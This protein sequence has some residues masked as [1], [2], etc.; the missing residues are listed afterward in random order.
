MHHHT[1]KVIKTIT[2]YHQAHGI[3]N[4]EAIDKKGSPME[5]E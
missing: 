3:V 2:T 1:T 4:E 5:K